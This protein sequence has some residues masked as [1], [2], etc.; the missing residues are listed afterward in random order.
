MTNWI[1]GCYYIGTSIAW[2]RRMVWVVN[3][4]TVACLVLFHRSH[5]DPRILS[6]RF[7]FLVIVSSYDHTSR[8]TRRIGLLMVGSLSSTFLW[9]RNRRRS[10]SSIFFRSIS[11]VSC[12]CLRLTFN[13]SPAAP[14]L[15]CACSFAVRAAS[16]SISA[17]CASLSARE[18]DE[19][20]VASS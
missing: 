1:Q 6:R 3:V 5:P 8:L 7:P 15:A 10:T 4:T 9:A 16:R 2:D 12:P 13:A 11:V 18:C 19:C 14:K 17:L 20:D